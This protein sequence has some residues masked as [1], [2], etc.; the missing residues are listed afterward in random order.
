V[1]LAGKLRGAE[2]SRQWNGFLDSSARRGRGEDGAGRIHRNRSRAAK[3]VSPAMPFT[4]GVDHEK[5]GGFDSRASR[6]DSESSHLR[7]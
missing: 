3:P 6:A 5:H 2:E 4:K 1:R 7:V